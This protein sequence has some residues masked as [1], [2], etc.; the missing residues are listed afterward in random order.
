MMTDLVTLFQALQNDARADIDAFLAALKQ[1]TANTRLDELSTIYH[2][3][4]F[5]DAEQFNGNRV[6][7]AQD[8]AQ[9]MHDTRMLNGLG[10]LLRR[11]GL[12]FYS[13]LGSSHYM[14]NL[15]KRHFHLSRYTPQVS[16]ATYQHFL[17]AGMKGETEP[18]RRVCAYLLAMEEQGRVTEEF[19]RQPTRS[20]IELL[21][22][23]VLEDHQEL[24]VVKKEVQEVRREVRENKVIAINA[25]TNIY[26]LQEAFVADKQ[27]RLKRAQSH[28]AGESDAYMRGRLFEFST[29]HCLRCG[30]WMT[31]EPYL[32]H[33]CE[34]DEVF[35]R[36]QGHNR[37]WD[38]VQA[39]CRSCN[40]LKKEAQERGEWMGR[41]DF[42]TAPFR[43]A[44][45][46]E[47]KKYQ[48]RQY[49]KAH[50]LPLFPD[51]GT[52]A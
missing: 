29:F 13:S 10:Q 35:P 14:K 39:L 38:N 52:V 15:I 33:S 27:A 23:V 36:G 43:A 8:L 5:W 48:Q 37:E 45:A 17:L 46:R 40:G 12:D 31:L 28:L 3:K 16:F 34:I 19:Q 21:R 20:P 30:I 1:E 42:R 49:D 26:R 32:P 41:W 51:E 2:F 6:M 4:T 44:C 11:Y 18:A 47:E 25:Q 50:P 7:L 9:L 22:D 24:V